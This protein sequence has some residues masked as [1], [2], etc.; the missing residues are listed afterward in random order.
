MSLFRRGASQKNHAIGV[1]NR[2]SPPQQNRSGFCW[3]P[4]MAKIRNANANGIA[5]DNDSYLD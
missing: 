2:L 1:R 3:M 5:I 4:V